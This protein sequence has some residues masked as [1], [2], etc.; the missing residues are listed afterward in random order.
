MKRPVGHL[1]DDRQC[2]KQRHVLAKLILGVIQ[3]LA[4]RRV[5]ATE[6]LF[7]AVDGTQVVAFVDAFGAAGSHEYVFVVIR[8]P[9]DFMR[10]DLADGKDQ[11]VA[12]IAQHLVHLCLPWSIVQPTGDFFDERRRYRTECD[13]V[14]PP[15]VWTKQV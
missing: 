2:I 1:L 6:C 11:I 10:N 13:H 14:V 4:Q 5:R 15:S 3:N 8:H 12:A 9:D 7:D